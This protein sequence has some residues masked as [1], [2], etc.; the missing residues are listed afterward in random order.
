MFSINSNNF[1]CNDCKW[2]FLCGLEERN[3]KKT[4][5]AEFELDI[6]MSDTYA[7]KLIERNRK[8]F[9][10]QWRELFYDYTNM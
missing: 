3:K 8:E 2:N 9:A 6:I 1:N 10:K 7:D 5:C 4:K